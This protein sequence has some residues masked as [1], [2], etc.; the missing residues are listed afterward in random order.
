[1]CPL[2]SEYTSVEDALSR[3]RSVMSRKP[4]TESISPGRTL[5]RVLAED[6]KAEVDLP[7]FPTSHMDGY[8][9]AAAALRGATPARP[10]TL[11]VIGEAGPGER[12]SL[13]VGPGEAVRVATGAGIP[14]GADVVLPVESVGASRGAISVAFAPEPGSYIYRAGEDFRKGELL[15]PK[16]R[17][18]AP[19]DLGLLIA[20]GHRRVKVTRRPRVSVIPTGSELTPA[21]TPR[22]GKVVESHSPI[23]RGLCELLGCEVIGGS[24]VGDDPGKLSTT[25]KKALAASDFVI[26]LGGTSAG[27][28][29]LV[30]G[31]VEG[32]GADEIVHG[33]KL[34]RGRVTGLASVRGRPLLMLPGPVQAAMNA[35]LIV[36]APLIE[37]LAGRGGARLEFPCTL[38]SGWVARRRFSGFLKVVYVKLKPGPTLDAEPLAGETES[39]RILTEAQ[40][41]FTVP[42]SVVR[43]AAG[44][45]VMVRLLPGVSDF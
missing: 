5:G 35:F 38:T 39:I 3:I 43:L 16:G 45:R 6:V 9:V 26:T 4:K 37:T 10:I 21:D 22:R 30:V 2:V 32:L 23:I 8:A 11:E 29:D 28:H 19:Q 7:R 31:A 27:K 18:V 24:I 40:G 44:S 13:R 17:R 15:L 12:P 25:L 20:L 41:Y 42:E 33:L 14:P 34:D 36:G 1:M